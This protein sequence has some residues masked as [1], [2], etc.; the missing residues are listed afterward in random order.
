MPMWEE[1]RAFAAHA[2]A[3]GVHSIWVCDPW[4]SE[5]Q[6]PVGSSVPIDIDSFG[7]P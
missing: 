2:E 6:F 5:T 1:V 7:L 4:G 3:V